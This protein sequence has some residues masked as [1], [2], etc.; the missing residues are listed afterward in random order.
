MIKHVF[1]KKRCLA[2]CLIFAMLA[3]MVSFPGNA[4]GAKN[5]AA[6]SIVLKKTVG[7]D[8]TVKNASGKALGVKNNMKLFSGYKVGTKQKSYAYLSLDDKKTVKTDQYTTVEIKKEGRK[9]ELKILY[10]KLFFN[11]KEKLNEK[12]TMKISTS[13][14]AMGIRGTSGMIS[15]EPVLGTDG[16]VEKLSHNVQIYDG[17]VVVETQ[18]ASQ[19]ILV[20]AGQQ[21]DIVTDRAG[22]ITAV[23]KKLTTDNVP[24]FAAKEIMESKTL[25]ERVLR[26]SGF[27]EVKIKQSAKNNT[28]SE[29]KKTAEE[30]RIRKE[31]EQTAE[32]LKSVSVNK[33]DEVK[34]GSGE[35]RQPSDTEMPSPT[36]PPFDGSDRP[37]TGKIR[38]II[39]SE[40]DGGI[41]TKEI[42]DKIFE[43]YDEIWLFRDLFN[44]NFMAGDGILIPEGK[45]LVITSAAD[46]K[47][48]KQDFVNNGSIIVKGDFINEGSIQSNGFI[49]NSDD[50]LMIN[51]GTIQIQ[52]GGK[53]ANSG[54]FRNEGTV[55]INGGALDNSDTLLNGN[56]IQLSAGTIANSGSLLNGGTLTLTEGVLYNNGNI[57]NE[58]QS[59]LGTI[60]LDRGQIENTNRI[61]LSVGSQLTRVAVNSTGKVENKAGGTVRFFS[62]TDSIPA[63]YAAMISGAPAEWW[64]RVKFIIPPSQ[65]VF[66]IVDVKH[67][68]A[69]TGPVIDA[70]LYKWNTDFSNVTGN[71]TVNWLENNSLFA[72]WIK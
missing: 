27:E 20:S 46:F 2:G 17:K 34:P 65:D 37:Q 51:K 14:I 49:E 44:S 24:V 63:E 38:N 55:E 62:D 29:T 50:R 40:L 4:A 39:L 11:V 18:N 7:R 6:V 12:E 1:F 26:D 10:G 32:Q 72:E 47:N 13:N 15:V 41:L 68:E 5:T 54:D 64:H 9:N 33:E 70:R 25:L 52:A 69:A 16:S 19:S 3:G 48:K 30:E 23:Q 59:I 56:S 42:T 36:L 58:I 53:L 60:I 8:I 71:L 35:A 22:A 31:L 61:I 43:R 28:I 57:T 66:K 21:V 67:G 45:K